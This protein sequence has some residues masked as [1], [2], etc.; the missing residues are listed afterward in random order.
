M[1]RVYEYT[2]TIRWSDEN[3]GYVCTVEE[4]PSLSHISDDA[5]HP[6]EAMG[7]IVSVLRDILDDMKYNGEEPPEPK[8][9]NR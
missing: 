5:M 6:M 8:G 7:E 1:S 9:D 4:F 2:Y 3:Q